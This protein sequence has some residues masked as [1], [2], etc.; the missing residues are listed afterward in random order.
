MTQIEDDEKGV[1]CHRST[2]WDF[3]PY[4]PSFNNY[5]IYKGLSDDPLAKTQ[6]KYHLREIVSYLGD[7]RLLEKD[8]LYFRE[9][10]LAAVYII[11]TK[12]QY[13]STPGSPWYNNLEQSYI[14][15]SEY[16][17]GGFIEYGGVFTDKDFKLDYCPLP[18]STHFLE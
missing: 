17:N 15:Y 9:T 5:K 18:T 13:I 11:K 7:G 1:S 16:T 14:T 12:N 4:I 3:T 8:Q 10:D 6:Q 2:N